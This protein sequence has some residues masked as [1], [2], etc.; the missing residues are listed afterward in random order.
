[1]L[2]NTSF[3]SAQLADSI[4][5]IE[6]LDF[7]A[8]VKHIDEIFKNQPAALG[9][10]LMLHQHD[11]DYVSMEYGLHVLQV[12]YDCFS[13]NVPNLPRMTE[14]MVET[15]F[16]NVVDML[17]RW[18]EANPEES[19]RQLLNSAYGHPECFVQA[20]VVSYLTEHMDYP[21][22]EAEKVFHVSLA[23]MNAFVEAKK[24]AENE[25]GTGN[26]SS[27]Q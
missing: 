3:S 4:V 22:P 1:M 8:K 16:M 15:E 26:A 11:V 21:C 12:L 2:S 19:E 14:E 25:S 20:F 9:M 6:A 17:Q 13:R 27:E 7:D 10:I 5:R 23:V 18:E 24:Q